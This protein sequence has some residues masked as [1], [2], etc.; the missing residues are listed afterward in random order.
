MGQELNVTRRTTKPFVPTNAPNYWGLQR[1][2]QE[3]EEPMPQAPRAELTSIEQLPLPK[4][5][6]RAPLTEAAMPKSNRPEVRIADQIAIRSFVLGH[7]LP[8]IGGT[9][10][11]E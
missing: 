7:K 8:K 4:P 9:K 2:V 6:V 1:Q 3:M 11:A 10:E 5:V